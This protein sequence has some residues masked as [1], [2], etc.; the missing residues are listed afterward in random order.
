MN[1]DGLQVVV[2]PS[3]THVRQCASSKQF[4]L[5]NYRF[6]ECPADGGEDSGMFSSILILLSLF[7]NYSRCLGI[8]RTPPSPLVISFAPTSGSRPDPL[9]LNL[10]S[11]LRRMM[12]TQ[13]PPMEDTMGRKRTPEEVR[14]GSERM[15]MSLSKF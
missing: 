8:S 11:G 3:R 12:A 10:T 5:S 13:L 6:G 14:V 1:R 15:W 2:H 9:P 7:N 4:H